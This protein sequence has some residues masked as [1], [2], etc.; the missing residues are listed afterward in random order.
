[1]CAWTWIPWYFKVKDTW[2]EFEEGGDKH[3]SELRGTYVISKECYSQS[4]KQPEKG[5]RKCKPGTSGPE[6]G[7]SSGP[8]AVSEV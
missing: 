5:E 7:V 4:L 2:R 8:G 1:M 3:S 6:L